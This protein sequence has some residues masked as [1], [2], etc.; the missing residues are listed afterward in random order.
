MQKTQ[1][2]DGE[3]EFRFQTQRETIQLKNITATYTQV[4]LPRGRRS[5]IKKKDTYLR[6]NC[7]HRHLITKVRNEE[8]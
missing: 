6:R 5:T 8:M 2:V 4:L 1:S 3:F 7:S